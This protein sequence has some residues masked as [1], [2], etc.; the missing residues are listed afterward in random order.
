MDRDDIPIIKSGARHSVQIVLGTKNAKSVR[1]VVTSDV[2]APIKDRFVNAEDAPVRDATVLRQ[3]AEQEQQVLKDQSDEY[4]A[5]PTA[6]AVDSNLV[7]D[8]PKKLAGCVLTP[9]EVA[10]AAVSAPGLILIQELDAGQ[11]AQIAKVQP[12]AEHFVQVPQALGAAPTQGVVTDV[13]QTQVNRLRIERIQAQA[14][15]I[16]L[17]NEVP[18]AE[19]LVQLPEDLLARKLHEIALEALPQAASLEAELDLTLADAEPDVPPT[20]V[21]QP[22]QPLEVAGRVVT[23]GDIKESALMARLRALKSNMSVTE[24]RLTKLDQPEASKPTRF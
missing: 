21:P 9:E 24:N 8:E 3:G 17:D 5:E 14:N 11:D 23:L 7:V 4:L 12:V 22:E 18:A 19:N 1:N 20:P 10:V 2:D 6:E 13:Q 15:R 16:R